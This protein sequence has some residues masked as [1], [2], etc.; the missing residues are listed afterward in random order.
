MAA[1][2]DERTSKRPATLVNGGTTPLVYD[3]EGRVIAAGQ[4]IE[5][6][7]VCEP[8]RRAAELGFLVIED[9]EVDEDTAGDPKPK[10]A[11]EPTKKAAVK[12]GESTQ[13]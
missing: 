10:P 12:P 7:D 6:D 11:P 13:G 2:K 1:Q 9:R 8:A 3:D 5:V 4:R